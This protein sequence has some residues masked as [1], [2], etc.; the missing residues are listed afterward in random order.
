MIRVMT[1]GMDDTAEHQLFWNKQQAEQPILITNLRVASSG[2][3]F[4]HN[5]SVIKNTPTLS[6]PFK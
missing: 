3:V 4:L 2:M 6:V 5:K 1:A